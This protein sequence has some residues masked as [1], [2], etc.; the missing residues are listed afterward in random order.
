ML[1]SWTGFESAVSVGCEEV[2]VFGAASEAFSKKNINCTIE[3]SLKRFQPVM[4]AAK[5]KNVAVRGS[6]KLVI[7]FFLIL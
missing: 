3:E 6:D 1:S 4:D 2:A 7:N 5:S